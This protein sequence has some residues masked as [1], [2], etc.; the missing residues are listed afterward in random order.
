MSGPQPQP[1]AL[2]KLRGNPG[3]RPLNP[4]PIL[5]PT[6][7]T[8]P[9]W[10]DAPARAEWKRV[11]RTL[12][13]AGILK[14]TDRA[15]LAA[16]CVAYSRWVRF[17]TAARDAPAAVKSSTSG[18]GYLNPSIIAAQSAGKEMLG[19]AAQ[20]GMTP[21]ARSRIAAGPPANEQTLADILFAGSQNDTA[22]REK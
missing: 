13:E 9:R 14:T 11:C 2:R 16:Y 20:L 5:D 8:C 19:Y 7:P 12:H 4:E 1:T 6:R 10:L 18:N 17:E 21:A 15:V 3:G 22:K